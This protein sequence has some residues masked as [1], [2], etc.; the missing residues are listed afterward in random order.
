MSF[1]PEFPSPEVE[2]IWRKTN[3]ALAF[4]LR[5]LFLDPGEPIPDHD[6]LQLDY[7]SPQKLAN[8]KYPSA[9]VSI[10]MLM[11]WNQP[12]ALSDTPIDLP[13]YRIDRLPFSDNN[14]DLLDYQTDTMHG[15]IRSLQVT[16]NDRVFQLMRQDYVNEEGD[17]AAIVEYIDIGSISED[18]DY[19]ILP[20]LEK[21]PSELPGIMTSGDFYY[22]LA[23][24][25]YGHQEMVTHILNMIDRKQLAEIPGGA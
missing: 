1:K 16:S 3:R 15:R 20:S 2:A 5:G 12:M 4:R 17:G 25:D 21:P 18:P 9:D 10:Y 22:S 7:C 14:Q 8:Q 19:Q 24:F 23:P 11:S 6:Y 13:A